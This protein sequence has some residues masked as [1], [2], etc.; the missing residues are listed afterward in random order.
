MDEEGGGQRVPGR[1]TW[2]HWNRI[3]CCAE[4]CCA[5]RAAAPAKADPFMLVKGIRRGVGEL[6]VGAR[7]WTGCRRRCSTA[8]LV[9]VRLTEAT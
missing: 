3:I 6:K 7:C 8:G 5:R 4:A 1:R 2:L 9:Q